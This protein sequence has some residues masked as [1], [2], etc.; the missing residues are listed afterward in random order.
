MLNRM[1]I[2][3]RPRAEQ[4]SKRY[5]RT[6]AAAERLGCAAQTMERWRVEGSGPPFVKLTNKLVV[7]DLDDL[8]GW[9]EA[10]KRTSTSEPP[11]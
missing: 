10:R 3:T 6:P 9:C 2:Q 11:R 7:Y 4:Q 5:L 1:S 8:D